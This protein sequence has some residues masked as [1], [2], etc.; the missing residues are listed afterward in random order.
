[1]TEKEQ[2]MKVAQEAATWLGTL[3]HH[4]ARVKGVGVDCALLLCEVYHA[5][6]VV[7]QI[8]PRPYPQNWH[9]HRDAERYLAW[10][11]QFAKITEAEPQIGDLI[12]FKFGRA[13][14]HAAIYIGEGQCIHSLRD[15]G[16]VLSPLD[17]QPLLGRETKAYTFWGAK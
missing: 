14:S 7:P 2:R 10:V 8:D 5:A 13:F 4:Q 11:E 12:L 16:V 3:Y 15:A 17:Q 9:M 1:M 6:G